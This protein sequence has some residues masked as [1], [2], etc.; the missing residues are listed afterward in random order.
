MYVVMGGR[1]QQ[2]A[3]EKSREVVRDFDTS[4]LLGGSDQLGRDAQSLWHAWEE[5]KIQIG[6]YLEN[7]KE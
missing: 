1:K 5:K 4:K 2:E 6:F 7:L 3:G